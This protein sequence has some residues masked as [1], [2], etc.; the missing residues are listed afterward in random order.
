MESN[1]EVLSKIVSERA[2]KIQ[3]EALKQIKYIQENAEKELDR[4]T[5]D[6]MK[7]IEN[8]SV[9]K[10]LD[11]LDVIRE[12]GVVRTCDFKNPYDRAAWRFTMGDR[13]PFYET[14]RSQGRRELAEGRYRI[15]LIMEKL[16]EEAEG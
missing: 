13:D 1:K 16:A 12:G 9:L 11:V 3:S 14:D 10:L 8:F 5:P 6:L 7:Q 4:I 15:T 2:D